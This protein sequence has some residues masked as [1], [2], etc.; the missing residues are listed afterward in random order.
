MKSK[1][2]IE[3][4]YNG[5]KTTTR[6]IGRIVKFD[7]NGAPYCKIDG[8]VEFLKEDEWNGK[9]NGDYLIYRKVNY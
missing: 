9:P 6:T 4:N 2:T 1:I 5:F 3:T 8:R 7:T